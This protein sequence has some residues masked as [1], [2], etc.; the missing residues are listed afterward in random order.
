MRLK[1]IIGLIIALI[2]IFLFILYIV[3][4]FT[5]YHFIGIFLLPFLIICIGEGIIYS[6]LSQRGRGF[7]LN[8][9]GISFIGFIA[10]MLSITVIWIDVLIALIVVFTLFFIIILN[11]PGVYKIIKDEEV[12]FYIG[13]LLAWAGFVMFCIIVYTIATAAIGQENFSELFFR[14]LP[15]TLFLVVI[16]GTVF[17]GIILLCAGAYGFGKK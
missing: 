4:F 3:F 14:D 13:L 1:V 10:F 17:F 6:G 12:N 7:V 9:F 2:G 8:G 5:F 16:V 11:I 15:F